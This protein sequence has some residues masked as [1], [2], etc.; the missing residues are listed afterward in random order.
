[1][2]NVNNNYTVMAELNRLSREELATVDLMIVSIIRGTLLLQVFDPF[3]QS[4]L[5][6]RAQQFHNLALIHLGNSNYSIVDRDHPD[7]WGDRITDILLEI[8]YDHMEIEDFG[9]EAQAAIQEQIDILHENT[10]GA[11]LYSDQ[12][13]SSVESD[14]DLME[15]DHQEHL[16]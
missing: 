13:D 2:N 9:Q 1:M 14:E 11:T 7:H 10:A 3:A 5:L 12:D 8:M 4:L 16:H 15:L 6:L